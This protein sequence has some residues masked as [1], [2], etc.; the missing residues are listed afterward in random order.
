[1]F[2]NRL[3]SFKYAFEGIAD[4][5]ANT[6]NARIHLAVSIFIF[7]AGFYFGIS[8]E[9][10]IA[11]VFCVG[12][13]LTAESLNTSIEYLTDLVTKDYHDLAKKTKDV[14][15]GAVLISAITASAIG[16]Y[17]FIP[18]VVAQLFG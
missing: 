1:M 18:Y 7:L 17:I 4:L 5:F 12:L 6:P 2:K 8:K 10:W 11:V 15:A 13:V 16:A 14:A 9:E 3:L